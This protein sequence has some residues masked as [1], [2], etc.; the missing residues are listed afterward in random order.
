M[1]TDIHEAFKLVKC[2]NNNL[3]SIDSDSIRL[4]LERN[5]EPRPIPE[6]NL[7]AIIRRF[8]RDGDSRISYN[9]F[10]RAM[11]PQERL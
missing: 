6:D 3:V 4:F 1:N 7:V 5:R 8:D 11:M 2:F 10:D 9:E